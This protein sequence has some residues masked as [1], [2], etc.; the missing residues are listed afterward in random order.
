VLLP[1]IAEADRNGYILVVPEWVNAFAKKGWQ[2]NGE[3]HVYVTAVLRDAVRHFTV[4]NDRVFLTGVADGANM[5]MD[6]GVSHPDLFAGV[7]P[8]GPIPKWGGLF[9][10]YWANAQ[11]LPFYV[12]TGEQIGTGMQSLR[13]IYE[14]WMP[15]GFPAMWSIYF[16]RGVEWYSAEAPVIFDWMSRKT[17][18]NGTATLAL[19]TYRQAWQMLRETDNRFYWLQADKIE[20]GKNGGAVVP[21]TIQGDI[22]GSLVDVQIKGVKHLTIWLS[23]EMIDWTKPLS[24]RINGSAPSTWQKPKMVQQNL[25]VLLEDYYDRGDRRMLFLNKLEFQTNK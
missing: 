3:D 24:V 7:I 1:L 20:V 8:M 2:W 17:R 16:G 10:E 11:K 25:E 12:V 15:R 21:A 19:G 6:V 14:K 5:A 23:T 13:S 18:V 22:R 4:D 9:V